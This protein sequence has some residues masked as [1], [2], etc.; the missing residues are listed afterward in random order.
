VPTGRQRVAS[1]LPAGCRR[2]ATGVWY[3][4]LCLRRVT[5]GYRKYLK[6]IYIYIFYIF[7]VT[8][9]GSL[10]MWESM[11]NFG[12]GSLVTRWWLVGGSLVARW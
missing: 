11:L 2:V 10:R 8:R 6:K 4:L 12:G 9:G 5:A 1:E 3:V 7:V